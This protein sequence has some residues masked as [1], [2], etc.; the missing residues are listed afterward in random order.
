MLEVAVL[1]GG[2]IGCAVARELARAGVRVGLFER[3]RIGAESSAAAAGM[4][5]VQGETDDELMLQLGLESRA[6]F[7]ALLGAL[8]DESGVAVEFWRTG[9]LWVSFTTAEA[10]AVEARRVWQAARGR[11][12]RR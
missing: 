8:R 6:L 9:T 5:G 4:L 7:P 1:G 11:R 3:G 10:A 12:A 2:L